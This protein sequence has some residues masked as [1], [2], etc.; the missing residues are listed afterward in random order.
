M[1]KVSVC[2]T[3]YNRKN[4]ILYA[5]ENILNQTY[6]NIQLII[7]DDCSTDGSQK[8]ISEKIKE[9]DQIEVLYIRNPV[10]KG[11][12]FSRNLSYIH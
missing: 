6:K 3:T 12:A 7:V 2:L 5:I 9:I 4:N 10:N 11:L 8:I 1:S